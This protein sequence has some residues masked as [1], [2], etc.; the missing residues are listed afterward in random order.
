MLKK[1]KIYTGT[2]VLC[3]CVG[4][5]AKRRCKPKGQAFKFPGYYYIWVNENAPGE[6]GTF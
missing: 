4:K 5:G 3:Q 2:D 6:S 1:H